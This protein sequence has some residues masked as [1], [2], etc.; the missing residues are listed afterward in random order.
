MQI[1][2]SG[3]GIPDE[4]K[5]HIFSGFTQATEECTREHGGAG[6]GL[7]VSHRL[8]Q[9]MGSSLTV[10]SEKGA[11]A[12]AT[13]S[14]RLPIA[15][16]P[17]PT[18][19]GPSTPSEASAAGL[20][21]VPNECLN[22]CS[23]MLHVHNAALR[24]QLHSECKELGIPSVD[25]PSLL[26]HECVRLCPSNKQAVLICDA[27]VVTSALQRGWK[28]R[29]VIAVCADVP[30]PHALRVFA[31]S[32]MLPIKHKQFVVALVSA[33]SGQDISQSSLQLS[34]G[35]LQVA[36]S[37]AAPCSAGFGCKPCG[38]CAKCQAASDEGLAMLVRLIVPVPCVMK[39]RKRE[40][41]LHV[42]ILMSHDWWCH[43]RR[44]SHLPR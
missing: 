37:T 5:K 10:S 44:T 9:L 4:Y 34:L 16:K 24:R 17:S 43:S 40:V 14:T 41:N 20:T 26:Y 13:L 31:T 11:G 2:D 25:A 30:V 21:D 29:G 38:Y 36:T 27:S 12:V 23:T 6:L 19:L 1:I 15:P 33:A 35:P 32:L 18:V 7:A 28:R 22:T 42:C 39:G 3:P 8:A